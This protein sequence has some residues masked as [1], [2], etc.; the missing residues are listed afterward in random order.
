MD[1]FFFNS[2]LSCPPQKSICNSAD[3]NGLCNE[4]LFRFCSW[5][6]VWNLW[7][8]AHPCPIRLRL[9]KSF[10]K[11]KENERGEQ[12][13][14]FIKVDLWMDDFCLRM[15]HLQVMSK[16]FTSCLWGSLLPLRGSGLLRVECAE[17]E[18]WAFSCCLGHWSAGWPWGNHLTWI[19]LCPRVAAV[20]LCNMWRSLVGSRSW[21]APW[22]FEVSG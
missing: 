22:G 7:A 9:L 13:S 11:L 18:T 8:Q 1:F 5:E 17:L 3:N 14:V 21:L 2:Y 16:W 19:D 20:V 12:A 4:G 15:G 6:Q 10:Q